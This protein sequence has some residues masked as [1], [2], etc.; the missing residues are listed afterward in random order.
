MKYHGFCFRLARIALL[1]LMAGLVFPAAA[2]AGPF[3]EVRLVDI[4]RQWLA[5]RLI[6]ESS[7]PESQ[8]SG[9]PFVNLSGEEGWGM[10][11]NGGKAPIN[12]TPSPTADGLP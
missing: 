3:R 6:P 1:L 5:E 12:G 9:N 11:P 8:A 4:L 2:Q 10:D 7:I